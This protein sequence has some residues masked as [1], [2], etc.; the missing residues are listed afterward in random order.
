MIQIASSLA[1]ASQYNLE[2]VVHELEE[3]GVDI[4]HF[5]IEDG[6]FVPVMRMGL[7]IIGDL[8]PL[9]KLP[10]DVHLM[11]NNP[12]WLIPELARAGADMISVHFEACPYPRRTLGVISDAGMKAGLAFNPKTPL[13]D[14]RQYYP[15][16]SFV[17]ILT[18]EPELR[19]YIYMPSILEKVIAGK[20]QKGI[21]N[22][23]WAVDGGFT[24][25]NVQDAVRVGADIVVSGRG[26]FNGN[27]IK[28]N[29]FILKNV[30]SS[31][32]C[33]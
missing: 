8:R 18:T 21:E 20:K 32:K 5:D 10:F 2:S 31:H 15:Y 30:S 6:N 27:S 16:L 3:A 23:W 24:V 19:D 7:K 9:T 26:V 25:Q 14:L 1:S 13:P 12:E 33:N 11:I 4:L 28:E 29:I 17:L 22:V